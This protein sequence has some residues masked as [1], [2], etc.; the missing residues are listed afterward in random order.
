MVLLLGAGASLRQKELARSRRNALPQHSKV[1]RSK[2]VASI[3]AGERP[4]LPTTGQA[5][6]DSEASGKG[7]ETTG[8]SP[9]SQCTDKRAAMDKDKS[10]ASNGKF[11]K[12]GAASKSSQSTTEQNRSTTTGLGASA[13]SAKLSTEQ[14][15]KIDHQAASSRINQV[16]RVGQRRHP[17]SGER[18]PLSAPRRGGRGLSGVAGL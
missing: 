4:T 9:K 12:N 18:A 15:T 11:E 10:D 14:C 16:E 17:R 5:A 3:K 8:Q 2:K 13:G 1:H 7:D 6:P